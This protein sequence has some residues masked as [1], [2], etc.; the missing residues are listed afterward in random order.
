MN[1]TIT[2]RAALGGIA[3]AFAA[4]AS[5]AAS[6][7][8]ALPKLIE[9]HRLADR[10][11]NDEIDAFSKYEGTRKKREI[12]VTLSSGGSICCKADDQLKWTMYDLLDKIDAHYERCDQTET[13]AD[14]APDL[15]SEYEVAIRKAKAADIR[16]L[17]KAIKDE[18]A[19][20]ASEPYFIALAKMDRAS[21]ADMAAMREILAFQCRTMAEIKLKAEYL[22]ATKA[23][24]GVLVSSDDLLMLLNSMADA[25]GIETVA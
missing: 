25:T 9:A 24:R 12:S 1:T 23:H 7:H 4:P 18:Q 6:E 16:A 3:T 5:V 15:A 20:R 10:L 14:F 21:A 11:F 17:R 22:V 8:S 2:R 19:R 13:L